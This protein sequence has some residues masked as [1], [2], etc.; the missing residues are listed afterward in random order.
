M[1]PAGLVAHEADPLALVRVGDQAQRRFARGPRRV[2]GGEQ[3]GRLVPVNA[4]EPPAEGPPLVGERFE[5]I[6]ILGPPALL[7]PVGVESEERRVGKEWVS[8][9]ITRW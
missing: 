9:F 1:V 6:G 4:L 7:V 8:K 2:E 5:R 3:R